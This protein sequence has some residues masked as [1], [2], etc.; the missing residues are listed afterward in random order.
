M[1]RSLRK[2]YVRYSNDTEKEVSIGIC[3]ISEGTKTTY[4]YT[5]VYEG[6]GHTAPV[7]DCDEG[8]LVAVFHTHGKWDKNAVK[9]GT[10]WNETFSISSDKG[11]AN[12]HALVVYLGTPKGKFLRFNPALNSNPY[13]G[14][15]TKL[16]P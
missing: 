12:R 9:N 1:A 2:T 10:D 16:K 13:A 7:P 3:R 6:T 5:K 15:I 8:L 11:V 14:K 4:D